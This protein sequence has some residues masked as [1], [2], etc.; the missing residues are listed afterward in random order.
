MAIATSRS[1]SPGILARYGSLALASGIYFV[2]ICFLFQTLFKQKDLIERQSRVNIWFLAQT[3]IEYLN[4]IE[5]LDLF[6]LGEERVTKDALIDRFEIFWSRLPVLLK[7]QQSEQ[8]RLVD[9]LVETATA[10]VRK[11]EELE[12][13]LNNVRR[14]DTKELADIRNTLAALHEP[15]REMVR[16]ALLFDNTTLAAERQSHEDIYY[17]LLGLFVAVLAAGVVLFLL[18]HRQILKSRRLVIQ[19]RDAEHA[20]EGA[21]S[22]L[23]LAIE[24][25]SEGFI[26]YDQED[27]VALFNQRY[28]ELHPPIAEAIK[29]GVRFEELLRHA[30]AQGGIVAPKD[31]IESWIVECVRS[32]R[33]PGASF[34]SQLS[35]G[36]SLKISERLT[37]DGRIVGVHTDITELKQRELELTH[38]SALLQTTSTRTVKGTRVLAPEARRQPANNLF[39][40]ITD[41]RPGF[42]EPAR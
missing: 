38:K 39:I 16:N 14:G 40:T 33:A 29:I 11:I 27:R 8:L 41:Y 37:S 9:G 3:E 19:A 26:I 22:E 7:G 1:F 42:S 21:R 25:I 35:G 6:S 4:F 28:K 10:L 18:L 34:E 2:A 13:A 31:R 17:Q 24:S 36:R 30:V 23:V 15:L 12:P 20:A 5:T 32:H